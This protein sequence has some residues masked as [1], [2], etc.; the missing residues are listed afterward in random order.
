MRIGIG[1]DTGG[2]YTDAVAVDR[3]TKAVLAKAK[4]L[5]TRN[6][7]STGILA[8]LDG[9]PADL[10]SAA[11]RVSLSTTLATNACVEDK[12]GRAKLI[13]FGGDKDVLEEL[14]AG[15][16]LP[17][18]AEIHL[19]EAFTRFSGEICGEVDWAEFRARIAEGYADCAGVGIVESNAVK[20]GGVVEK[21]ARAVFREVHKTPVVCGFELFD[22]LN[23][24]GRAA[25]TLLNARL[26]PVIQEFLDAIHAAMQARGMDARLVIVR[27][28]GSLMSE[29]FAADRPVETLLCGPAASAL[30]AAAVAG[31]SDAVVVDMG[32]TT[33]DIALI[34]NGEPVSAVNGVR[35]GKWR[36]YVDGLYIKTVGLGGD[37][38]V[39]HREGRLVLEAYRVVPLCVLAAA[40]PAVT[41]R[42]RALD[43]AA[44]RHSMFLHEHYLLMRNIADSPHYT[45]RERAFCRALQ[46]GPLPLKDAAEA[47][48]MDMYNL[49]VKRL[50]SEG[51]VAVSGLTPTDAM[52]VRG[53][54]ARYDAEAAVLAARFAAR[55]LH[56]DADAVCAEIYRAVKKRMY[57]N[58]AAALWE[59]REP[60][61]RKDGV[62]KALLA[63]LERSFD[64][65]ESGAPLVGIQVRSELPLVGIGAPIGVFL[66][67]VARALGTKAVIAPHYEVANA[68]GAAFAEISAAVSVRVAPGKDE[69]D[70]PHFCVFAPG[71]RLLFETRE[72]A[73]DAAL[74]A[75]KAEAE[76]ECLRRGAGRVVDVRAELVAQEADTRDGAVYLGTEA[77]GVA[78]GEAV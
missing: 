23:A 39:H 18:V 47:V 40:Y 25:S 48:G 63:E 44:A 15:Y 77:R 16:G 35:V 4:A 37:S 55:C 73:E 57:V 34:R 61:Y 1:I 20:N 43:A 75:A 65:I 71:G 6:D 72:E 58:V 36:A 52:H 32:G 14:G 28:N 68:L 19:Q 27:S 31:A 21:A 12:G 13:F 11:E 54:F 78:L 42:L 74:A 67:D 69:N 46:D 66:P 10:R 9:L 33:T 2:T 51:V 38:A 22:A 49:N 62:P 24:L 3:D 70:L 30:G 26:F 45:E 17:P 41:E 50:V 5:T 8:A 7:L 53:D 29:A 56:T 64:D 60:A 59:R 76:A